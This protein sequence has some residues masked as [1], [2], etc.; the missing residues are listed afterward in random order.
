LNLSYI[1][2]QCTFVVACQQLRTH[3]TTDSDFYLHVTSKGIV[4]DCSRTRFAPYSFRYDGSD[5]DF[6][7]SGLSSDVNHW[8]EID[9]FNWLSSDQVSML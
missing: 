9:D 5:D 6:A 8:N 1:V 4:E 7:E 3:E 2:L